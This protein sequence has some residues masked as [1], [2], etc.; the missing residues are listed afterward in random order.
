MS[1]LSIDEAQG[2][3]AELIDTLR[4]GEEIILTKGDVPVAKLVGVKAPQRQPRQPGSAR[5]KLI[6]ISDDDEHLQDFAD[7]MP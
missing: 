3:L 7:Y 4:D 5:G 2:R 1:V 6:I